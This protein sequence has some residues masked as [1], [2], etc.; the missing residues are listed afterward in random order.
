MPIC[1][2]AFMLVLFSLLDATCVVRARPRAPFLTCFD[3]LASTNAPAVTLSDGHIVFRSAAWPR[4]AHG[5][6]DFLVSS[7]VNA[8]SLSRIGLVGCRSESASTFTNSMCATSVS[9]STSSATT[10]TSLSSSL[11]CVST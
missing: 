3:S 5:S 1:M 7:S 11:I 2:S 8:T 9:A 6:S 10:A 4:V